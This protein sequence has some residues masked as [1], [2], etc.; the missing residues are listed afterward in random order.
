MKIWDDEKTK[1]ENKEEK[2]SFDKITFVLI[3]E[4]ANTHTTNNIMR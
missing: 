1:E 4:Q 3:A 2:K